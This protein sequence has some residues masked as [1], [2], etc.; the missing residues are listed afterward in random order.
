[1][2]EPRVM[3]VTRSIPLMEATGSYVMVVDTAHL[4]TFIYGLQNIKRSYI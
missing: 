4:K 2:N 3:S 1:M